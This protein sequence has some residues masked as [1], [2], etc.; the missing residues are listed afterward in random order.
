MYCKNEKGHVV[1]L[2]T[3]AEIAASLWDE[4]LQSNTPLFLETHS[5]D[6]GHPSKILDTLGGNAVP[7]FQKALCAHT[8]GLAPAARIFRIRGSTFAVLGSQTENGEYVFHFEGCD[9][10][11]ERKIIQLTRKS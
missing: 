5:P 3:H 1:D 9:V 6:T 2:E 8:Q 10:T 11:I 4:I 7:R